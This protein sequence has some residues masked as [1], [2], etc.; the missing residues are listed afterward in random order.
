MCVHLNNFTPPSPQGSKNLRDPHTRPRNESST[1]QGKLSHD[2][3]GVFCH[4]QSVMYHP[5][6]AKRYD[7]EPSGDILEPS[8]VIWSH[9][10]LSGAIW[11]QLEPSGVIW[12]HM[13]PA[14]A[15]WSYLETPGAL[16]PS[17]SIWSHL[18]L[19]ETI[20][21]YLGPS[22]VICSYL[23]PSGIILSHLHL[24]EAIKKEHS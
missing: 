11:S 9:L 12:T 15:F 22:G 20:W 4:V 3:G 5:R 24:S 23:K 7:L 10:E 17:D 21:S 2:P 13:E 1:N 19:S 18:E 6:C 14:G 8:G 16:A